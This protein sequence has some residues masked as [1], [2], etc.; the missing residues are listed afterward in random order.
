MFRTYQP[1]PLG[2]RPC[3][4]RSSVDSVATGSGERALEGGAVGGPAVRGEHVLDGKLEQRAQT[5]AALLDAGLA[6]PVLRDLEAA[7]PLDERVAGDDRVP[8][9]DPQHEVV[10]HHPGER[11]DADRQPVAGRE[12]LPSGDRLAL[13]GG[14]YEHGGAGL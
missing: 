3:S 9:L 7:A 14:G 8:R 11:L 10:L 1:P 4:L 5:L 12:E 13:L 2:V 6:Q